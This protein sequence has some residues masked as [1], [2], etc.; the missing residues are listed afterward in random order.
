[1]ADRI[2][3]M[4]NGSIVQI[5]DPTTLYRHP[6]TAFAA[7]FVGDINR[8]SGQ[9]DGGSPSAP[10]IKVL[11]GTAIP[12]EADRMENLSVGD[13]VL[14]MVRPEA[15]RISRSP[16]NGFHL[17]GVI[18]DTILIGDRV[19]IYATCGDTTVKIVKLTGSSDTELFHPRLERSRPLRPV[20]LYV[21]RLAP[22]DLLAVVAD[23]LAGGVR[24][25]LAR[26]RPLVEQRLLAGAHAG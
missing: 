6:K 2:A 10:C 18:D 11:D 14:L 19:N 1:M 16:A 8:L 7:E 26:R 23:R 21:G 25:Q 17:T 12:F 3:V 20:F 5:A 13:A 22:E 15:V 24:P 9:I 4:D